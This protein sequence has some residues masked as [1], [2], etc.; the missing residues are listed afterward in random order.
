MYK[1]NITSA[2][3]SGNFIYITN[4][5]FLKI[6]NFE[7]KMHIGVENSIQSIEVKLLPEVSGSGARIRCM[8]LYKHNDGEFGLPLELGDQVEYDVKN[9]EIYLNKIHKG[10]LNVTSRILDNNVSHVSGNELKQ[11]KNI[12]LLESVGFQNIGFWEFF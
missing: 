4:E 7:T 10:T 12:F 3:I 1:A 11:V 9:G 6:P 2:R 5:A 8:Y